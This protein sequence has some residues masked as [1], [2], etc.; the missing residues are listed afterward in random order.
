MS[1]LRASPAGAAAWAEPNPPAQEAGWGPVCTHLSFHP[2]FR[3]WGL[4][5]EESWGRSNP[6]LS[7]LSSLWGFIRRPLPMQL[8][9]PGTAWLRREAFTDHLPVP[10]WWPWPRC[11]VS[12]CSLG[13]DTTY[14]AGYDR[15]RRMW[16]EP[17]RLLLH[18]RRVQDRERTSLFFFLRVSG[19][20][21]ILQPPGS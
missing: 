11:F 21:S 18:P 20:R 15:L 3:H 8:S 9:L 13:P 7:L 19:A 17:S 5:G 4:D 6:S 12:L 1:A 16:K 14:F 10:C 2:G